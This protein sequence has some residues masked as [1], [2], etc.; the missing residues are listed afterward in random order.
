MAGCWLFGGSAF[1]G[2][3]V[4]GDEATKA[5][6]NSCSVSFG[7]PVGVSPWTCSLSVRGADAARL[8]FHFC[9]RLLNSAASHLRPT[10]EFLDQ[11]L[12]VVG[13]FA[14]SRFHLG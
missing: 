4:G 7:E 5:A 10:F 13:P 8:A 3:G 9:G 12:V 11:S 6:V 1:G 2:S 14:T